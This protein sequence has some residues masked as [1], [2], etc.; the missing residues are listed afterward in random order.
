[1]LMTPAERKDHH[2]RYFAHVVDGPCPLEAAASAHD[3]DRGIRGFV[4]LVVLLALG[5][6]ALDVLFPRAKL[7]DPWTGGEDSVPWY[8]AGLVAMS[9]VF[10][11]AI[12]MP[13]IVTER[14]EN[15]EMRSELQSVGR[16]RCSS[17]TAGRRSWARRCRT[18]SGC[19]ECVE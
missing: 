1:M 13:R 3:L 15:R 19:S 9:V 18:C 16:A 4:V 8:A 12:V 7:Y 2:G 11:T 17:L 6:V 5:V 10:A 14:R